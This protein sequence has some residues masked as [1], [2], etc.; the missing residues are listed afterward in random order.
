MDADAKVGAE[1]AAEAAPR[2]V[3]ATE[4][5]GRWFSTFGSSEAVGSD[6]YGD[7]HQPRLSAAK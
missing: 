2:E 1:A 4:T 7:G 6:H 3:T 5:F